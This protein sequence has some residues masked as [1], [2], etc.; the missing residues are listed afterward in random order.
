MATL[1]IQINANLITG[2]ITSYTKNDG[3]WTRKI[4]DDR[5]N[6]TMFPGIT[7]QDTLICLRYIEEGVLV[8]VMVP[9]FG[10]G[11]NASVVADIFIP[12]DVIVPGAEVVKIINVVSAEMHNE[13]LNIPVLDKLFVEEYDIRQAIH[14]VTPVN[15]GRIAVREYGEGTVLLYQLSKLLDTKYI[16]QP[17]YMPYQYIFLLDK[18]RRIEAVGV[19]QLNDFQLIESVE[20]HPIKPIDGFTPYIGENVFINPIYVYQGEK[21]NVIWKKE[22]YC[23]IVKTYT[24]NKAFK[25][26]AIDQSEYER[27]INYSL[28]EVKDAK[29]EK[30]VEKYDLI[31][32]GKSLCPKSPIAVSE[33]ILRDTEIKVYADGYNDYKSTHDVTRRVTIFLN[34]K[35]YTYNFSV[36]TSVVKG[37]IKFQ[38][39]SLGRLNNSPLEG[40]EIYKHKKPSVSCDNLLVYNPLNKEQ[41]RKTWIIR[42]ICFGVGLVLGV[43][44][45][46]YK[47]KTSE[48]L[49]SKLKSANKGHTTYTTPTQQEAPKKE[50]DPYADIIK[51]MDTNIKW[52]KSELDKYPQIRGLWDDLNE[53]KFEE[54]KRFRE[55]LKESTKFT[56]LISA[57]EKDSKTRADYGDS[58]NTKKDDLDITIDKYIKKIQSE[59]QSKPAPTQKPAEKKEDSPSR[60]KGWMKK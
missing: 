46:I 14:Q 41:K 53:Y 37:P 27:L 28:V 57:I 51:Y 40:Y 56:E 30:P 39:E 17:Q 11:Q 49:E 32:N 44:A 13:Q 34:P 48:D 26:P 4:S 25:L 21:V 42:L 59:E 24:I 18:S 7:N 5:D 15:N 10:R 55:P 45:C 33:D 50:N 8:R 58:Y 52:N 29:T 47:N 60:S 9:K 54:I 3:S 43:I 2:R 36:E 38:L 19:Q 12:S 20:F 35:T 23:D 31:V 22:N 1:G 6:I 16:Y